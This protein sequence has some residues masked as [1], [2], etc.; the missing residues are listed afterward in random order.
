M[1][2][3][4]KSDM[5]LVCK[6]LLGEKLDQLGVN[7][8][9]HSSCEVE[10]TEIFTKE[11]FGKLNRELNNYGMEIVESKHVDLIQQIKNTIIHMVYLEEQL[12]V[13]KIS[14]YLANK[15]NLSY[16]YMSGKFSEA[17]YTT[18]ENFIILTKIDRVKE[19]I[20]T[21]EF[22]LS[23]ISVKMNYSSLAH[24][25]SQFKKKTGITPTEFQRIL[26]KSQM[27]INQYAE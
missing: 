24:L 1:L 7:H 4:I 27:H 18:I 10:I 6:K 13:S 2:L 14:R 12:P 5:H 21:G 3:F 15:L 22:N 11:R 8:S 26:K 23:E 16:S 9:I 25:S 17:T 20:A 19:L